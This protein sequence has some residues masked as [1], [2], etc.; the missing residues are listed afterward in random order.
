MRATTFLRTAFLSILLAGCGDTAGGGGFVPDDAD[1]DAAVDK[2]V[3]EDFG[4]TPTFDVPTDNTVVPDVPE[5]DAPRPDVTTPVDRP[6]TTDRVTPTDTAPPGMCP[7]SCRATS[8][9]DPCRTAGDPGNYCC[10]SGLCLY[11]TGACSAPVPDG[12]TSPGD[13]GGAPGDGGGD[14]GLDD[15][16]GLGDGGL[17]DGGGGDVGGGAG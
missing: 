8:D 1:T 16:G 6:I 5:I 2:D 3:V 9:C 4:P 11:M 10:I 12:G 7:S 17:D 13:G 14:G 15:A